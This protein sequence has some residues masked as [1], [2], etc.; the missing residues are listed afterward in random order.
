MHARL[1]N[2]IWAA[3]LAEIRSLF[4]KNR[5]AKYL[6]C[7]MD[8]FTKRYWVKPLNDKKTKTVLNGFIKEVNES[9]RKLNKLWFDQGK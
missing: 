6:L 8:V 3:N 7:V 2:N 4:S 5:N 9:K 1:K